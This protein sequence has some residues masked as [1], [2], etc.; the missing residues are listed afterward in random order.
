MNKPYSALACLYD[1]LISDENYKNWCEYLLK[2]IKEHSNGKKCLDMACG[3]GYF[4]R[5]LKR[6]GFL[7]EGWDLSTDMLNEAT[8]LSQKEGLNILYK[9]M[10]ITN[11]TVF[12][13]VDFITIV[14]DGI[15]YIPPQK[16]LKTFKNLYKCLK[17]EGVLFFDI[18]S[19]YKF[20]NVINNNV[21]AEDTEDFTYVWFNKLYEDRVDMDLSVFMREGDKFIKKEESQTQYIHTVDN[22]VQILKKCGYKSIIAENHLGGEVQQDSLRIQLI[23]KK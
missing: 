8:Q 7:V 21:F 1:G 13:K 10:D 23:A 15:N 6:N 4:T 22:L 16:L 5:L 12:E 18:S 17:N 3:S 14:N 20:L 2:I 9:Q 19:K 11:A